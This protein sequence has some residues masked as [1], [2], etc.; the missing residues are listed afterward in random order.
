M[1]D[2]GLPKPKIG[3]WHLVEM[4][5]NL[6]LGNQ[7]DLRVSHGSVGWLTTASGADISIQKAQKGKKVNKKRRKKCSFWATYVMPLSL[8]QATS[9]SMVQI[10]KIGTKSTDHEKK[11]RKL[12]RIKTLLCRRCN[13]TVGSIVK[14]AKMKHFLSSLFQCAYERS[15]I[16]KHE[17]YKRIN[18]DACTAECIVK[19][20]QKDVEREL[21]KIEIL[22]WYHT[23]SQKKEFR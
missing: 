22:P 20:I 2:G 21:I 7:D 15:S 19:R 18:Q 4:T 23:D 13:G 10:V 3:K 5:Q 6:A 17:V 14:R 12:V 16:Q 9:R 11:K 1:E 8:H